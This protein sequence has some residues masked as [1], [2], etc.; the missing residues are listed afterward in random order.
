MLVTKEIKQVLNDSDNVTFLRYNDGKYG[1]IVKIR[2][3]YSH[4]INVNTLNFEYDI[5]CNC[6]YDG[7]F[8]RSLDSHYEDS[9]IKTV[10]NNIRVNDEISI[11]VNTRPVDTIVQLYDLVLFV[12]RPTKKSKKLYTYLLHCTSQYLQE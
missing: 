1:M 4:D 2:T 11:Q 6:C 7:N 10:I 8:Y 5:E 9:V 3:K 12:E